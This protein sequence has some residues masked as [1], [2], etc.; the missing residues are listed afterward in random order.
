AVMKRRRNEPSAEILCG[1]Q[2][3]LEQIRADPRRIRRILLAREGGSSAVV[4]AARG[5]EIV[6]AFA[7]REELARRAAGVVHQGVIAEVEPFVYAGFDELA[8]RAPEC[9]LAADQVT[10]PRNLG[11]LVRSA[12]AAGVGGLI[13]PK[14]RT[15]TITPVVVKAAAGATSLLPNAQVSNLARALEEL[16]RQGYWIV[17]LDAG[18]K[19]DLFTFAFPSRCV[20]VVGSEGK[21]LRPL[22][23]SGCDHVVAV[24]MVGRVASLNVSVAAAV[25]LFERLRQ[26]HRIDS[27]SRR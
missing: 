4:E 1:M 18:G 21:G 7:P 16:K 3:V 23:R 19:E 20:I 26:R 27:P 5:A 8:A 2:P 14:D 12:E 13:L 15:A 25:V 10:D 22:T 6:V 24:P 17:G 9:L 11:A